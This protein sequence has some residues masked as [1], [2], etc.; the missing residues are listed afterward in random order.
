MLEAVGL[1]PNDAALYRIVLGAPHLTVPELA[2]RCGLPAATAH[3]SLERLQEL[4]MVTRTQEQPAKVLPTRPDVAIAALAARRRAELEQAEAIGRELARQLEAKEQLRPDR[5]LEVVVGQVS[6]A[7]RFAQ[8]LEATRTELLVLDMPP[9]AS[10]PAENEPGIRTL[11]RRDVAVHGIY[12]PESLTEPGGVDEAYR[13]A[14]AGQ[15]SRLHPQV[16]MKLAI[17]D[18]TTAMLPLSGD[19]VVDSALAVHGGALV[20]ALAQMFWLLWEQ[21]LPIPSPDESSHDAKL[22]T[23]LAGGLKDEAVAR[24]L[25]MS[26]RT[27]SRRVANLMDGLGA[28]TRFQAGVYAEREGLTAA[29]D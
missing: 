4:G 7:R 11:L 23:L 16:P 26:S 9:Y 29:D 3:E 18:Q 19:H 20:E 13:A 15:R 12:A 2:S 24:Q 8:L 25:N 22:L 10:N 6:I 21:A 14:E 1:A 27:V 28:R 17:F 5:L